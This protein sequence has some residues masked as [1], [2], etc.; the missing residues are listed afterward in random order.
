M[1]SFGGANSV[2]VYVANGDQGVDESVLTVCTDPVSPKK[3]P[4]ATLIQD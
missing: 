3:L 2:D 1:M 4:D